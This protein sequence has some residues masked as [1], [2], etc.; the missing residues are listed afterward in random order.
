M[1]LRRWLFIAAVAGGATCAVQA[2]D[3]TQALRTRSLAATCAQCHGT[4]GHA[5]K[6]SAIAGLAGMPAAELVA[7]INAF[8]SGARASTVM[9]QLVRGYSD[10]QIDRLAAYFAAQPKP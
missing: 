1:N 10:A 3:Q 2:Q 5:P 7:Q 4:D 8:R 6:D 9:Q